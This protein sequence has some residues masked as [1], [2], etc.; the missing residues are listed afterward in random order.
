[1]TGS[2]AV[3]IAAGTGRLTAT[4]PSIAGYVGSGNDTV[5]VVT[6]GSAVYIGSPALSAITGGTTWLKAALP[7]GTSSPDLSTLAVLSNPSQLIGLLSSVGGQ[8]TTVGSVD[9]DGTQTTEYRTT[10]TLS[11]L[12]SWAGIGAG[13]AMGGKVAKVLQQ[14]GSTSVPIT[15]WVGTDGYLRQISAS[16]DLSRATIGGVASDVIGGVLG[17]SLP[18]GTSGQSTS[19][20]TV[21]VGFDQYNAPVTVTVPP[22]S[23]TKD[24]GSIISSV[25][26]MASDIGNA[27]SDVTSRL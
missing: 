9:L 3:D 2:G 23:Q 5:N 11:E 16:I 13:S 22:A 14:L 18:T 8:V 7:K 21:T 1:M 6:D 25:H 4:V 26:H 12:A 27:V 15:A 17:G 20:T 24:L 10:V 19:A